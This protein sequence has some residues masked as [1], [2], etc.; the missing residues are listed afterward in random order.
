M[1]DVLGSTAFQPRPF[2][3]NSTRA[4]ESLCFFYLSALSTSSMRATLGALV[5]LVERV[6]GRQILQVSKFH[7]ERRRLKRYCAENNE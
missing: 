6:P 1:G 7:I 3:S 2:Q 4:T 5:E